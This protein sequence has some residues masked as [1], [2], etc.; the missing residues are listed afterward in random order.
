M[1]IFT[2]C[3]DHE[4]LLDD[5]V[6]HRTGSVHSFVMHLRERNVSLYVILGIDGS[7]SALSTYPN[8]QL[9]FTLG[10]NFKNR[11]AICRSKLYNS[12]K[13]KRV[14]QQGLIQIKKILQKHKK[15]NIITKQ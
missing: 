9:D 13:S 4:M 12:I 14:I 10:E 7:E 6:E 3:R 11:L 15:E 8:S 2:F 1:F 5:Y